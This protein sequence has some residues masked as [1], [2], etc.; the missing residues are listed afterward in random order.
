MIKRIISGGEC[1]LLVEFEEGISPSTSAKVLALDHSLGK[2]NLT[3]IIECVP[4]YCSLAVYFDPLLAS[5]RQLRKQ[6]LD[7]VKTLGD[8]PDTV[9]RKLEVPVVYGEEMGPDLKSV[10]RVHN[11]TI[12]EVIS[13]H[14]EPVY[15]VYLIGF[16]PG[17][18]YLGG[19]SPR[20]FT[21]RLSVP[22]RVVP[23]GSVAIGGE[24]TGIYSRTTPGGWHIIGRTTL[25]L[26]D[27][28]ASSPCLLKPGDH[29]VF[30]PITST[31]FY[32]SQ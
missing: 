1:M 31:E 19:L 24:Q 13:L 23:A 5:P 17:F 8:L 26:F 20:L 30:R 9:P 28:D 32:A 2:E 21:P 14:C 11:L 3:G 7:R 29:V 22:R 25:K 15:R 18:P 10:A 16:S 4:S 6:L 27:P 12:E